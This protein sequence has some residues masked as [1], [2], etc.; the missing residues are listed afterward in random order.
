MYKLSDGRHAVV[1]QGR[2][3]D[4]DSSKTALLDRWTPVKLP[5]IPPRLHCLSDGDVQIMYQ[6]GDQLEEVPLALNWT[7][8]DRRVDP[9]KKLDKYVAGMRKFLELYATTDDGEQI[10]YT[11]FQEVIQSFFEARTDEPDLV[12]NKTWTGRALSDLI[13]NSTEFGD[14]TVDSKGTDPRYIHNLQLHYDVGLVSPAGSYTQPRD[15]DEPAA[16][17][18]DAT[19]VKSSSDDANEPGLPDDVPDTSDGT[20]SDGDDDNSHS[21]SEPDSTGTATT[22]DTNGSDDTNDTE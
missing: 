9:E 13:K 3:L 18:D 22:T 17:A 6:S 12:P 8:I 11:E 2:E 7:D 16:D 21:G 1:H 19:A 5:F 4:T 20:E 14:I 10:L 15:L